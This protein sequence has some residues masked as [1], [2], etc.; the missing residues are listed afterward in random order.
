MKCFQRCSHEKQN[1]IKL[2]LGKISKE[3]EYEWAWGG[4]KNLKSQVLVHASSDIPVHD[5]HMWQLC[6]VWVQVARI[7]E[8]I[9][10]QTNTRKHGPGTASHHGLFKPKGSYQTLNQRGGGIIFAHKNAPV[11][12][13]LHSFELMTH[14]HSG[15]VYQGRFD[16][17]Q[18]Y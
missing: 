14:T 17:G 4:R 16:P 13:C 9:N 12:S 11:A 1:L 3:K 15:V 2:N 7:E 5:V 18:G 8:T 6:H 10:L